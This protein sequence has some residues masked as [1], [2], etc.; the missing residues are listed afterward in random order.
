[1][2][3]YPSIAASTGQNFRAFKAH[4]FDKLDGSNLRWEW[5]GKRGWYK[6]GTRSRLFDESDPDFGPAIEIFM[7]DFADPLAKYARKERWSSCVAFTEFWGE[8]SFAGVHDPKDQ[9]NLTLI[10]LNVYKKG[11]VD[12]R[13]FVEL[14]SIVPTAN[15]LGY[16]N[17]T[18][19]LVET[20]RNGELDVTFEGVV[21]KCMN[22]R[23][24]IMA[25]AKTQAWV[26]KVRLL[27][28]PVEAEKI[29]QS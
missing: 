29:I 7:R 17:W 23:K 26:D 2:K 10:D 15:Y 25:K 14:G 1:M 20:V 3:S 13:R 27:Y 24:R 9:K 11:F 16:F 5:W 8:N 28:E 19:G 4:V 6:F 21:G 12:P 22:G 18:R